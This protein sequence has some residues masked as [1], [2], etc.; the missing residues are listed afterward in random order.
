MCV[1]DCIHPLWAG[2]GVCQ[3]EGNHSSVCLCN[4]GYA[5]R[6]AA[7]NPSCVPRRV[8]FIVYLVLAAASAMVAM[9]IGR[10]FFSYH[11]LPAQR[12]E[13][14]KAAVRMKALVS[15]R[16]EAKPITP[17]CTTSSFS[18]FDYMPIR[19]G[20]SFLTIV[21]VDVIHA[22]SLRTTT[23]PICCS[24]TWYAVAFAAIPTFEN[25]S[26]IW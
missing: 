10:Q 22:C 15:C 2:T 19:G 5:S 3:R 4:S 21:T 25:H 24:V 13:A 26:L 6:D 20:R 12:Q 18:Q 16:C 11:S 7:G 23:C 1:Q 8:L 17:R 14:P 9:L